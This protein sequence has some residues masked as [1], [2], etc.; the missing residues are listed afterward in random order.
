MKLVMKKIILLTLLLSAFFSRAQQDA[1]FTHYMFNT[2]WL[3]PAYAGTRDALTVTG[4]NRSQW[5]G[6]EGAPVDQSITLHSP[7]N[8]GKMGL[9]LSIQNGKI[10]PTRNL[11]VGADYAYQI[12]LTKKSKLGLGLKAMAVF[13]NNNISGVQLEDQSQSDAAFAQNYRTVKPNFGAGV[14]YYRERFYAGVSTPKLIEN[15]YGQTQQSYEE[16][17]HFYFIMGGVIGLS[18]TVKFKPT[19]FIKATEAAPIQSDF[20]AS[21][22]FR[23]HFSAGVMYRTGDA[24]GVLLGYSFSD[25]FALGYSF[26][27]SVAN[28]TGKY[29]NGSHEIMLRYDLVSLSKPKIKSPRYF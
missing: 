7:L 6:F 22:I 11:F 2:L 14:Y 4:I 18:P 24:A 1:M 12:K 10:G 21:F 19:C 25:Q 29:N 5:V 17:R 27:W 28:T 16:K 8:N 20:T 26:D 15:K 9:G 3:N 13:L 23:D